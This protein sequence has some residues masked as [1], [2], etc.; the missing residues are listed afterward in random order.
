[1]IVNSQPISECLPAKKYKRKII[2]THCELSTSHLENKPKQAA[3]FTDCRSVLQAKDPDNTLQELINS[4]NNRASTTTV[5][6][7]WIHA[8]TGITGNETADHLAK[9]GSRKQK[10]KAKISYREAKTLVSNRRKTVFRNS[11]GG[12]NPCKDPI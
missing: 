1:M 11:T 10:T 5:V 12:Y 9:E 8:H 3:I 2:I 6:L 7:Q 4:I